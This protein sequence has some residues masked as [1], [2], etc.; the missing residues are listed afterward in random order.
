MNAPGRPSAQDRTL[1][2]V[3]GRAKPGAPV[4]H[5]G[6][7][8]APDAELARLYACQLFARRGEQQDLHVEA[9]TQQQPV[10]SYV[11]V[12]DHHALRDGAS[13]SARRRMAREKGREEP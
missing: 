6:S 9:R 12:L 11:R 4:T 1:Y 8:E 3:F 13:H 7:L 5:L 10:P 2:D